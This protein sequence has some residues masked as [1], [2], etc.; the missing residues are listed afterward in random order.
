MNW[1]AGMTEAKEKKIET[2]TGLGFRATK[3]ARNLAVLA[4]VLGFS[5]LFYLITIV[6]MF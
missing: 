4:A 3:R 5:G 2:E 1:T 6:R